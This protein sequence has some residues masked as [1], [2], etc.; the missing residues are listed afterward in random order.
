[1]RQNLRILATNVAINEEGLVTLG[2][3]E[4]SYV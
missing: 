1:M 3:D 2:R 4:K